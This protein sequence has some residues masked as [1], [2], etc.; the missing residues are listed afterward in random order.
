MDVSIYSAIAAG[1]SAVMV[2]GIFL[3]LSVYHPGRLLLRHCEEFSG[4]WKEKQRESS[5]YQRTEAKLLQNGAVFHYGRWIN[6]PRYL[7]LRILCASAGCLILKGLAVSL[8]LLGAVILF[9]VPEWLLFYLNKMDNRLMLPEIKLVFHALEIQIKAGV[10]VTD[11]L[12]EC[13]GSVREKR[14]QQALL[15]LAGQIV[16]QSD[17]YEAL[18]CFQ[19]KFDNRHIDSLCI[20]ILQACE[21]GQAV[22]LLGDISENLKDVESALMHSRKN[23]LDRNI[24]FC[25]LGIL[26]AVLI[27][28]I[29]ACVSYLF[30]AAVNL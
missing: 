11:A 22:E 26:V 28:V 10:Y 4:M 8:G 7:L 30:T 6:P 15:D 24:T 9:F 21:S 13:Y 27:V 3:R 20:T 1:A 14:L 17:L 5:W 19:K 18:D 2:F 25:Q 29:Y 16:M 23:S 12:S